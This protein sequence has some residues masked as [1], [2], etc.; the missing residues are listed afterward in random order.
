MH[1]GASV[2][3]G[4]VAVAAGAGAARGGA[5]GAQEAAHAARTA[6]P[7]IRMLTLRRTTPLPH[8]A[9]LQVG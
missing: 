7:R 2:E 9:H 8:R 1:P 4:D 5:H 6:P 3:G